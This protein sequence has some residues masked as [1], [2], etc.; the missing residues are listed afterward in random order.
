ML[1]QSGLLGRAD[2]L[3]SLIVSSGVVSEWTIRPRIHSAV[4]N[5][6]VWCYVKVDYQAEHTFYIRQ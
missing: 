5:I 3:P 1:Y 6:V 4:A 2:I